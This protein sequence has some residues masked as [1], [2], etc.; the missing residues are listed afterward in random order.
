MGRSRDEARAA[1]RV[2]FGRAN[3]LE[4]VHIAVDILR[5]TLRSTR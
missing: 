5:R 4:D 1:L 2:S 3:D